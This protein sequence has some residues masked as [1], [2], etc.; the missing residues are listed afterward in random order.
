MRNFHIAIAGA[1]ISALAFIGSAQ[2]SIV[3]SGD[4]QVTEGQ[5]NLPSED[6]IFFDAATNTT[7][8]GH[9][10]SQTGTTILTFTAGTTVDYKNGFASIDSTSNASST[11]Y[12]TLLISAPTGY[13]FTDLVFDVLN[14]P[15]FSVLASNGGSSVLTNQP[16]GNTEYTALALHGT[17]LTWIELLSDT[18]FKQTKQFE[19]SGLTRVGGVPE[20]STWAMLILG[21]A[22]VG[23]LA[24]RRK[25]E[26]TVLRVA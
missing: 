24:Y 23:F 26:S 17:S 1:A 8:S 2:A 20:T 18:G 6:K 11:F 13:T 16:N 10:G 21:F 4:F 5:N 12:H 3:N 22:G 15:N 7:T 25:N 19:V 9:V 14:P